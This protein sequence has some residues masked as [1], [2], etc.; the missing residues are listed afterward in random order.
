MECNI[1]C[2]FFLIVNRGHYV[3]CACRLEQVT[4]FDQFWEYLS[5]EKKE[6]CRKEQR[7]NK[8]KELLEER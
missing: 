2:S 6:C 4:N 3:V 8:M 7:I 1:Q 5:T